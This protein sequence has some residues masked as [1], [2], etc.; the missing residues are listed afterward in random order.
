MSF[1][2][3]ILI[4]MAAGIVVGW[5]LGELGGGTRLVDDFLVGGVFAVVGRVFIALLQMMVAPLV[6]FSL[7]TG[8]TSLGD[9]RALGRLGIK[10]LALYLATT[11]IA[12]V[13][14]LSIAV[15]VSPGDGFDLAAGATYEAREP[16][17][18]VDVLVGMVPTNP[19][20]ALADGEML[21]IIVFALLLGFAISVS[22]E[23][24]R[25]V[26]AIFADLNRVVM[27]M[28][29]LVIK[30]APVG[31]FALLAATFATEGLELILPLAGYVLVVVA[32]FAVH[33]GVVYSS[34][35]RLA[36]LNPVPFFAKL[37]DV[38]SFAFSTSSSSATIPVT[39]AA[40][41]RRH[42][43]S[44]SVAA[45]TVPLGATINMDGTAVMQGA[46]TVFIANVYG[47]DLGLGD[48]VAVI[49]TATLASIGTA[50]APGAGLIMLAIVLQQVGLPVEGIAL[51][52][53]VERLIDMLRTAVNVTGDCVVTCVVARSEDALDVEVFNDRNAGGEQTESAG[54]VQPRPEPTADA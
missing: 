53:G 26:A 41:E 52:I 14:V 4:A 2:Q 31:V 47:I 44:N 21:Q 38:M 10:T 46:A 18:V 9:I 39:L 17:G 36:R 24:G 34:L 7:V 49:L 35:L 3:K 8:V 30:T 1:T 5:L 20:R 33:V 54:R 13:V 48:F 19:V 28:V 29:T 22:G 40:L 12:L 45:F 32:A 43:V 6:L 25:R 11:A 37:R 23:A 50:G 42:G 51:I 27:R 15:I 16:P